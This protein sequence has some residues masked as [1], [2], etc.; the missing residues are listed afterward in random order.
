MP[1][2]RL[3]VIMSERNLKVRVEVTFEMC[4]GEL[5]H[6]DETEEILETEQTAI[7]FSNCACAS[8]RR[9]DRARGRKPLGLSW[10]WVLVRTQS[11]GL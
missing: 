6:L 1:L 9:S 2:V 5:A 8:R 4:E 3:V 7:F 11:R 10:K